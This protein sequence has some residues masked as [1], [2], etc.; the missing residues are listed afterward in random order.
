MQERAVKFED[1]ITFFNIYI[2]LSTLTFSEVF[3]YY[4]Y[5]ITDHRTN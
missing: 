4:D 3:V 1:L 2:R 5:R